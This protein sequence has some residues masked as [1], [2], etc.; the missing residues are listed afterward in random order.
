MDII[1][2]RK[3]AQKEPGND[4]SLIHEILSCIFSLNSYLA[5]NSTNGNYKQFPLI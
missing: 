3:T 5:F 2:G 1:Y 4:C